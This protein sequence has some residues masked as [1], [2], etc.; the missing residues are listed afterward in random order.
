MFIKR[1]YQQNAREPYCYHSTSKDKWNHKTTLVF[2]LHPKEEMQYL[3]LVP[4]ISNRYKNIWSCKVIPDDYLKDENGKRYHIICSIKRKYSILE[5][6]LTLFILGIFYIFFK[7]TG[8]G[9]VLFPCVVA[10]PFVL[11]KSPRNELEQQ[12]CALFHFLFAILGAIYLYFKT[13]AVYDGFWLLA[14][15]ILFCMLINITK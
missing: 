11:T 9:F 8:P 14:L 5:I 13:S 7:S 6:T 15:A 10:L 2:S 1:E 4:I 12:Q 3:Q